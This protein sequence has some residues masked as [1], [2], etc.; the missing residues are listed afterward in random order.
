MF[1]LV[2]LGLGMRTH[3]KGLQIFSQGLF[4]AGIGILYLSSYASFNFYHLLPQAAALIAMAAVTAI[5]FYLALRYEALSIAF[6]GWGGGFLTPFLLSIGE[7]GA[8]GLFSYV[9]LLNLGMLIVLIKKRAMDILA[10]LSLLATAAIYF[11]WR[12][13]HYRA[14]DLTVAVV[15]LA[16][17]WGEY[18]GYQLIRRAREAPAS[19]AGHT[20]ALFNI[21]LLFFGLLAV[22]DT[23]DAMASASAIAAA[24]YLGFY[25]AMAR[26]GAGETVMQG[27]YLL[28]AI[29]LAAAAVAIGFRN[30]GIIVGWSLEAIVVLWCGL[31]W[32]RSVAVQAAFV[33]LGAAGFG[34][35]TIGRAFF[36]EPIETFMPLL[37]ERALTFGV[38]AAALGMGAYLLGKYKEIG[39]DP[40]RSILQAGCAIAIFG[41]VTF[42]TLDYFRHLMI[43]RPETAAEML[44][45]HRNMILSSAWIAL[46]LSLL[47]Y[48]LVKRSA[49]VA[50]IS[51][52]LSL[53]TMAFLVIEGRTY[54]PIEN[55]SFFLNIRVLAVLIVLGTILIQVRL[56]AAHK[57]LF[58]WAAGLLDAWRIAAVLLGL[59]LLTV[60]A[61]DLFERS[62][63]MSPGFSGNAG[64]G[65]DRLRDLQQLTLSGIWL[66]YSV[67]TMALGL[68]RR[69]RAVRM[70]SIGLFGVSILKIFTYDLSFLDT[71]YRIFSFVG[72][73]VILLAV[74]YAYQRY[75]AE[76]FGAADEPSR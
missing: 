72:L 71:L 64:L 73:G 75:K 62:I 5:A 46:S 53:I 52:G 7:A 47:W 17:V 1:G 42:E 8:M 31:Y 55:Y 76:I 22:I 27:I 32:K 37:N 51:T 65:H 20:T 45:F 50:V 38:L 43:A 63:A 2:T 12:L 35:L 41:L 56:L 40:A 6:L 48:G 10:P 16:I 69:R 68:W 23:R 66:L 74:S 36:Y 26:R 24:A 14:E 9:I 49:P 3:A 58:S 70:I 30:F 4:G 39:R 34:L 33:L 11:Y 18:V 60:E 21:A 25:L 61:W 59:F 44:Q 13:N 29:A 67:V 57:T 28:A 19:A 54:A 15:F